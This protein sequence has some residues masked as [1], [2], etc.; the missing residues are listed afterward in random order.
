MKDTSK[1]TSIKIGYRVYLDNNHWIDREEKNKYVS[2]Y[3]NLVGGFV[4]VSA[5]TLKCAINLATDGNEEMI[6]LGRVR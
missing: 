4:S 3:I 2:T 5:K 6:S 1:I